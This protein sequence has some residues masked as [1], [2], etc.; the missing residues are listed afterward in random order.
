MKKAPSLKYLVP[1]LLTLLLVFET[2]ALAAEQELSSAATEIL[3]Q[4]GNVLRCSITE[5]CKRGRCA[6]TEKLVEIALSDIN[7]NAGADDGSAYLVQKGSWIEATK[8][9]DATGTKIGNQI[10]IILPGF[11]DSV[12]MASIDLTSNEIAYSEH[13]SATFGVSNHYGSCEAVN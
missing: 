13:L 5:A 4:G 6:N 12:A 9:S 7:G 8:Q 1:Y 10:T 2:P 11:G 3:A